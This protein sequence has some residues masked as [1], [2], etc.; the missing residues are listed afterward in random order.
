MAPDKAYASTA[1]PTAIHRPFLIS[2][3]GID[4]AG[5]TT[6]I[7]YLSA[8]LKEHLRGEAIDTRDEARR[9]A[10]NIAK[11]PALLVRPQY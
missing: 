10:V 5:K 3:S 7:D 4:G 1:A 11:L 2:F 9:I 6:Q 8:F